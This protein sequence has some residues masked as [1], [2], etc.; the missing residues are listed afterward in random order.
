MEILI[1]RERPILLVRLELPPGR[2][3]FM[4]GNGVDAEEQLQEIRR[5]RDYVVQYISNS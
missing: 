1:Y 3:E 4:A 5:L 2:R